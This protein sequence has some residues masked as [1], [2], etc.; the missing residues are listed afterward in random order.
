MTHYADPETQERHEK[1]LRDLETTRR[2]LDE[3]LRGYH[4]ERAKAIREAVKAGLTQAAVARAINLT[5][6]RVGQI[7]EEK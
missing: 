5:R 1:H 2:Y 4:E 6:S 3:R 7:L